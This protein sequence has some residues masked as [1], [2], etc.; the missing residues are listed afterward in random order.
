MAQD[1][2]LKPTGI[3]GESQDAKH[4]GEIE[5][6]NWGWSIHQNSSMQSGSGGGSG[7]AT[8]SDLTFDHRIDRATP[9]L[10]KHCLV[11]KHIDTATLVVRKAGG[12]PLEYFKLTMSN[13]IVTGVAPVIKDTMP[14]GMESVSLSFARVKQE[15]VVQNSQGGTAG[16]V[17][18]SFDIQQNREA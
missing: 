8:V 5:L 18:A 14:T 4:K 3:D 11:G 15:Y 6:T 17:A 9:N 10:L 7:K 12:N 2:F 13:V 1:I 16:T